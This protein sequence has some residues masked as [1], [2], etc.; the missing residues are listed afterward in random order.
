MLSPGL[1]D[2]ALLCYYLIGYFLLDLTEFDFYHQTTNC[3]LS[4]QVIH[5]HP[6]AWQ[7]RE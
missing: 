4:S 1:S 6:T 7:A 2:K 3:F 5:D